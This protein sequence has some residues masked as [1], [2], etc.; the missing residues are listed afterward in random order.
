M[1]FIS[2]VIPTYNRPAQLRHCLAACAEMDYPRER[3]EIVVVDD[4]GAIPLDPVVTQFQGKLNL[5]LLRQ[6][7][8][9][10]AGARNSGV[11][12]SIGEVLAFTDDDC[13]PAPDWL[14]ALATQMTAFPGC[15]VGGRTVNALTDNLCSTASQVLISYLNEYYNRVPQ[16]ARFFP[17]NNL[18]FPRNRF[19]AAGGF[20][21]TYPRAAGEDRELCDRW[22]HQGMRM[23][24]SP[25][26]VVHHAHALSIRA[27]VR[28][29][30]NYGRGAYCF[31]RVRARRGAHRMKVE[32]PSFYAG[33]F[34]YPFAHGHGSQAWPIA[35]LLVVAQ[36]ANTA[37]FIWEWAGKRISEGAKT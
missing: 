34:R 10:P 19:L 16:A 14:R 12:E 8:S 29:H 2:I 17:S 33:M 6:N 26:A 32:P 36:A 23:V 9:G 4:G 13:A 11:A 1:P 21:T 18:A 37:G 31:H 22:L 5:K 3:F 35:A 20:D 15:A 25:E 27:F 30:F 28:Q 24:Y 7:N